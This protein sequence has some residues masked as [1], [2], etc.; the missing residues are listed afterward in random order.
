MNRVTAHFLF[1]LL[2]VIDDTSVVRYNRAIGIITLKK[3]IEIFGCNQ[4]LIINTAAS[5]F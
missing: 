5:T 2:C 4:F 3:I 1:L